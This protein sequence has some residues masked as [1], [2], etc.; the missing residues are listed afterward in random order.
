MSLIEVI[1][2]PVEQ[3]VNIPVG[4]GLGSGG[5][6]GFLLGRGLP[7]VDQT[8]DIPVPLSSGFGGLQGLHPGQSSTAFP[9]QI[10]DVPVLRG[11]S[12]DFHPDAGSAA[13]STEP[14]EEAFQCVF[15][16]SSPAEKSAPFG[17]HLGVATGCGLEFIHAACSFRPVLGG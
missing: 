8:V 15:S 16:T 12:H 7:T 14:S 17:P 5:L 1:L 6:Q 11:G 4:A 10:V 13:L 2:Q 3:A 9:E